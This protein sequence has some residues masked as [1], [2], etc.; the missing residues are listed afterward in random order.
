MASLRYDRTTIALHW[1]TAAL[2]VVLWIIGQTADWLPDGPL[3]SAYWSTHVVLGFALAAVLV[4]RAAWRTGAGRGLPAADRGALHVLAKSTHY[5]LYL[6]LATVVLLGI[7]NAF[8]RGYSIFGLFHLPQIGAS[9]WRHSV[10]DWH[11][12]AANALLALAGFHAAAALVHQYGWGDGLLGRMVLGEPS[13]EAV[14][15]ID[16]A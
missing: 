6:L 3:H 9:V 11:G 4:W 16:P 1:T 10:T 8:V 12:L 15:D 14:S 13:A 2:V 7:I 5:L